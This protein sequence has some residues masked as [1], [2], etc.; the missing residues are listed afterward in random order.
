MFKYLDNFLGC[1]EDY[2]TQLQKSP[3]F[4]TALKNFP[5]LRFHSKN[6]EHSLTIFKYEQEEANKIN[7]K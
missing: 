7:E 4:K 1:D 3:W 2:P 6:Q 5:I